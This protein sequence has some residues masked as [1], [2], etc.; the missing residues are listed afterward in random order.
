MLALCV[1][2]A[3]AAPA[4]VN[5]EPTP[6]PQT[7][8]VD[9]TWYRDG[10]PVPFAGDLYYRTGPTV[11]FNGNTMVPTGVYDGVTLYAD[12]TLEPYSI[13]FMPVGGKLLQPYVPL[14]DDYL[15]GRI[16]NPASYDTQGGDQPP[17]PPQGGVRRRF[18]LRDRR[19][20]LPPQPMAP[21][22]EENGML[23]ETARKPVDNRGIWVMFQGYRWEHAGDAVVLDPAKLTS[24]GD[25][26]GAPVYADSHT[27]Y[28]IY[29]PWRANLVAPFR[30]TQSQ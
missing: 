8:A 6:L 3:T 11:Y 10:D 1:L 14:R 15:T 21:V 30:R 22:E 19:T 28:V 29:I 18:P 5:Y 9:R 13:V 23:V 25:Y 17:A 27:P 2:A 20:G 16:G 4:Q 12:A 7:S 24:V 26:S